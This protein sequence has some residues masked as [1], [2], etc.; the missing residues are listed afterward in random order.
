MLKV[1]GITLIK[2]RMRYLRLCLLYN[3][4]RTGLPKGLY[5]KIPK[6]D[7]VTQRRDNTKLPNVKCRSESYRK[8]FL[9]VVVREWNNSSR[10]ARE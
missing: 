1:T 8:T 10:Q 9:P 2:D 5:S 4:L 6:W 7:S 3:V